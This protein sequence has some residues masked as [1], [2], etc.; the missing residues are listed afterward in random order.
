MQPRGNSMLT[1]GRGSEKRSEKLDLRLTPA[2]KQTLQQAAAAECSDS[3]FVLDSALASA[4]E[5]LADRQPFHLSPQGW[6]AFLAALDA[7]PQPQL[8]RLLNE[9]SVFER[10]SDARTAD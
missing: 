2:A 1:T 7:P 5:T 6:E 4:A 9:P 8:A 10:C 3:D